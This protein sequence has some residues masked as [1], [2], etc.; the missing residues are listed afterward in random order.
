MWWVVRRVFLH[1]ISPKLVK[2][3]ERINKKLLHVKLFHLTNFHEFQ[4]RDEPYEEIFYTE[5]HPKWLR[6]LKDK[7]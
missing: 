7:K 2:K 6:N 5:F 3:Y 4:T 1:Q